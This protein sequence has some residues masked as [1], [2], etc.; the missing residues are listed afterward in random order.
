M[1]LAGMIKLAYHA[2]SSDPLS[3]WLAIAACGQRS[4]SDAA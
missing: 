2:D 1:P 4:D 3:Q